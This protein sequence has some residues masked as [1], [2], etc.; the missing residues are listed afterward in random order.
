M[1]YVGQKVVCIKEIETPA[2]ARY[3][4]VCPEK[5]H[6]YTIRELTDLGTEPGLRVNEIINEP[7][8]WANV[9]GEIEASFPRR[10]FRP[11]IERK[12]DILIFTRMLDGT[13]VKDPV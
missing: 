10:Y 5:G 4:I 11:V 8:L 12:T 6:V 2:T 1:F 7:T 9:A 13:R 3:G